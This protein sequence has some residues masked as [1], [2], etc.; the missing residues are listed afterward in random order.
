MNPHRESLR[1]AYPHP[2]LADLEHHQNHLHQAHP[3][4][5]ECHRPACPRRPRVYH[6]L[7]NPQDPLLKE[8][9]TRHKLARGKNL[10]LALSATRLFHLFS[11]PDESSSVVSGVSTSSSVSS[12][13]PSSSGVS[14]SGVSSSGVS[15]SGVSSSSSGISSS[16]ESSVFF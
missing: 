11:G 1:Q 16:G 14:S 4:V 7:A 5:Q 9:N 2:H 15:S 8:I 12:S 6:H 3:L 13:G 10:R